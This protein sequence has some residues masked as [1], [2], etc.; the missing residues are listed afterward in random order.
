MTLLLAIFI[1]YAQAEAHSQPQPRP[2][3]SNIATDA[4]ATTRNI[5]VGLGAKPATKVK[6]TGPLQNFECNRSVFAEVDP[7][8]T[9]NI[10]F[11]FMV[12]SSLPY[13]VD[14]I[15]KREKAEILR[16]SYHWPQGDDDYPAPANPVFSAR[17]FEHLAA[18]KTKRVWTE[19][20]SKYCY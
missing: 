1:A 15:E 11:S 19:L 9:E 7:K 5:L 10:K 12:I 14:V 2:A 13:A 8:E 4:G 20:Y 16:I 18:Y 6:P 3:G 17:V